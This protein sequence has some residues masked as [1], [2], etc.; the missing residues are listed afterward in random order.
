M[1]PLNFDVRADNYSRLQDE[2][3]DRA[4]ADEKYDRLERERDTLANELEAEKERTKAALASSSAEDVEKE[5]STRKVIDELERKV[6]DEL[7]HNRD[8]LEQEIKQLDERRGKLTTIISSLEARSASLEREVQD[9]KDTLGAVSGGDDD[10]NATEEWLEE[11][12]GKLRG[13][14]KKLEEDLA[15]SQAALSKEKKEVA[16]WKLQFDAKEKELDAYIA[17]KPTSTGKVTSTGCYKAI[18]DLLTGNDKLLDGVV[19]GMIQI[20][21]QLEDARLD[22]GHGSCTNEA[23][24]KEVGQLKATIKTL[25]GRLAKANA[26]LKACQGKSATTTDASSRKGIADLL[27]TVDG[28]NSNIKTLQDAL[29]A[30]QDQTSTAATEGMDQQRIT[31]LQAAVDVSEQA[32]AKLGHELVTAQAKLDNDAESKGG[33]VGEVTGSSYR[34]KLEVDISTRKF[35]T[36]QQKLQV[37]RKALADAEQ[38]INDRKSKSASAE[39]KVQA[40][41]SQIRTLEKQLSEVTKSRDNTTNYVRSEQESRKKLTERLTACQLELE[42]AEADRDK[43]HER[44][45]KCEKAKELLKKSSIKSKQQIEELEEKISSKRG[46]RD[47]DGG[48]ERSSKRPRRAVSM[49]RRDQGKPF[50]SS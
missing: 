8:A 1:S 28:L 46:R 40:L 27:T 25:Q 48:D 22:A 13:E 42:I 39:N 6:N 3:V 44:L 21:K 18:D 10:H 5:K 11:D 24:K 49:E 30:T 35:N 23:H 50:L 9:R 31:D 32:V 12:L 37:A 43:T 4:L 7:R 45:N 38:D 17:E 16:A 19:Q 26:D 41:E 20:Q 14:R 29:K 47:D 33:S 34:L 15:A 36:E 2:Q